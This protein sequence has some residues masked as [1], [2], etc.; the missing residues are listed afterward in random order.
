HGT[1]GCTLQDGQ[2]T[3]AIC[4]EDH[5][6]VVAPSADRRVHGKAQERHAAVRQQQFGSAHAGA[7][8]GGEDDGGDA[9][10]TGHRS[11]V[12][13]HRSVSYHLSPPVTCD[14]EPVTCC[15]WIGP[16]RSRK[17]P[18]R[19]PD[20]TACISPTM[21]RAISS[22]VSPP[23]SRPSCPK[24]RPWSRSDTVTPSRRSSSR[25]FS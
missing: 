19:R 21:A 17:K 5:N 25:I 10:T 3:L 22:G 9:R 7:G 18:P 12:T 20:S 6:H 11:Q 8:P 16:L 23:M 13:A 4:T 1:G 14:L 2:I 15:P 24:M